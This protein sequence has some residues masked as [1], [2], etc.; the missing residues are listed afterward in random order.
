MRGVHRGASTTRSPDLD[1]FPDRPGTPTPRG[2]PSS[3]AT[4]AAGAP[5]VHPTEDAARRRDRAAH[6]A[7][8]ADHP[9]GAVT[10]PGSRPPRRSSPHS[11]TSRAPPPPDG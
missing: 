5:A 10:A 2:S 1:G 7:P 3:P 8:G 6:A 4:G 11:P 9:T